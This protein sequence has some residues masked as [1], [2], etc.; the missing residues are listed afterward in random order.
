M[1]N[2]E[3]KKHNQQKTRFLSTKHPTFPP[4]HEKKQSQFSELL[5]HKG[6]E[7][8]FKTKIIRKNISTLL[9]ARR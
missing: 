6:T 9:I 1:D 4:V 8:E 2:V 5:L 7:Q 3:N